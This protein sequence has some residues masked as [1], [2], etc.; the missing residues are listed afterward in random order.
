MYSLENS[1]D[2]EKRA[3]VANP[4]PTVAQIPAQ[5]LASAIEPAVM[6]AIELGTRGENVTLLRRATL[7]RVAAEIAGGFTGK[8]L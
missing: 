6:R 8:T 5:E 7:M 2:L 4:T 3:V 1:R